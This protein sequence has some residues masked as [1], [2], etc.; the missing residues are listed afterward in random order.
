MKHWE[1]DGEVEDSIRNDGTIAHVCT[2]C[3][4]IWISH[5]QPELQATERLQRLVPPDQRKRIQLGL[6]RARRIQ[7]GIEGARR[8]QGGLE[9]TAKG[10]EAARH[11]PLVEFRK[12]I[13]RAIEEEP[14]KGERD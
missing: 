1:D 7:I 8:V 11:P 4:K 2:A 14:P 13:W 3:Q 5:E 12:A 6:E 9:R 10:V